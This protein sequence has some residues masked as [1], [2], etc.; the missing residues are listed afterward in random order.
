MNPL[1]SV[2]M[3]AFREDEAIFTTALNSVLSQTFTD[4]E[5]VLIV[6]D[7]YNFDLIKLI[8][9]Y[10]QKDSRIIVI[11]NSENV[12]L[13]N[14]LNRAISFARGK[15]C[16]RMDSDDIAYPNRFE[17]QIAE[18]ENN[19]LDLV[20]SKVDVIGDNGEFLYSS[21]VIPCSPCAVARGLHWNNCVPH[22]TW[23]GKREV[24]EC[25]YRNIDLCEDYD[26]LIRAVLAGFRIGNCNEALMSYRMT[27]QSISRSN[28]YK[29]YLSQV[30]LSKCYRKKKIA[31]ESSLRN[32]VES[33]YSIKNANSYSRANSCFNKGVREVNN[34]AIFG[35]RY[36]LKIPFISFRY[37][38][39]IKRLFFAGI[40]GIRNK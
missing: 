34:K 38:G 20:G 13:A 28:L 2:L 23:M 37:C 1:L 5:L 24:F 12:G 21:T 32:W 3:P 6:D 4:F 30:Y 18:I 26:F 17:R 16:C 19:D 33:R 31:D 36:L 7:P 15:Y 9:H 22:P 10:A 8:K 39:K 14:S 29:Q 25:G 27:A 40:S 35:V 11:V